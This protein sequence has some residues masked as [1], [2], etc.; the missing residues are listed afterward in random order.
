[1]GDL[2]ATAVVCAENCC[3]EIDRLGSAA[4]REVRWSRE[5]PVGWRARA[6]AGWSG[7]GWF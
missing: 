3:R 7:E 1:M 5:L 6:Q 4:G 2:L